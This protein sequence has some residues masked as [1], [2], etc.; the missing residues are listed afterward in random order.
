MIPVIAKGPKIVC[1][2]LK[3]KPSPLKAIPLIA[4]SYQGHKSLAPH[5]LLSFMAGTKVTDKG[6]ASLSEFSPKLSDLNLADCKGISRLGFAAWARKHQALRAL[7]LSRSPIV[8]DGLI[9]V[10]LFSFL[11][12]VVQ[13][14]RVVPHSTQRKGDGCMILKARQSVLMY[15]AGCLDPDAQGPEKSLS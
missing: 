5:L 2:I 14:H 15:T 3:G 7:T 1:S 9:K 8:H 10:S 6:L 12:F 4:L 11:S 13:N